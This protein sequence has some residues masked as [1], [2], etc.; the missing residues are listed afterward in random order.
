MSSWSR[1]LKATTA[2]LL[3]HP[4]SALNLTRSPIYEFLDRNILWPCT[5]Y[6]GWVHTGTQNKSKE[7]W[8]AGQVARKF[9]SRDCR[10]AQTANVVLSVNGR[11]YS[12]NGNRSLYLNT[13]RK[14]AWFDPQQGQHFSPQRPDQSPIQRLPVAPSSVSIQPE[15]E[16]DQSFP[17]SAEVKKRETIPRLPHTSL[18]RGA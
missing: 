13:P 10:H 12:P 6:H 14:H 2:P 11:T 1:C 15:R 9:F 18:W 17:Y 16:A 8:L 4:Y 5:S 7:P 3:T